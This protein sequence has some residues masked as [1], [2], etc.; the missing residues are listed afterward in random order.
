MG[1][2]KKEVR[3]LENDIKREVRK[4]EKD[5]KIIEEEISLN[6]IIK[7]NLVFFIPVFISIFLSIIISKQIHDYLGL[8]AKTTFSLVLIPFVTLVFFFTIPYMR[9]R[10]KV[11]GF[12]MTVFGFLIISIVMTIPSLLKGNIGMLMDHL[13]FIA[14]YL[15][16]TFLYAPEVLG[17]YGDIR[18]WFKHHH[19]LIIVG[20]YL[21]ITLFFVAGFGWQYYEIYNDKTIPQQFNIADENPGYTTF[22]YYSMITFTTVG[23]GDISPVGPA[24]RLVASTEALISG[25]LNILFIAILLLYVSNLQAI[26]AHKED[27]SKKKQKRK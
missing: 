3:V 26:K 22:L 19:Q 14:T 21:W 6:K 11:K 23:Y 9:K 24:A 10:E 18:E 7:Y 5:V 4:V 8:T 25:I 20:I 15:L 12:R 1:K 16:L 27:E 17:I 13:I 2:L